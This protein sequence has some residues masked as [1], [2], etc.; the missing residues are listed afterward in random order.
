MLLDFK[1]FFCVDIHFVTSPVTYIIIA[2]PIII[3]IIEFESELSIQNTVV[4]IDII[5]YNYT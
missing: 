5:L 4:H 2:M 3:I 1:F